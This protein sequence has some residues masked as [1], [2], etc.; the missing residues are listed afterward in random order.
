MSDGG[1]GSRPARA[2][3]ATGGDPLA[4]S[5]A[6]A[7]FEAVLAAAAYDGI[8]GLAPSGDLRRLAWAV[9]RNPVPPAAASPASS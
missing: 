3:S 1:Q 5:S 6:G 7:G 4:D 8:G 2:G 9:L